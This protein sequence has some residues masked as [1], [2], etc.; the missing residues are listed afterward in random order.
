MHEARAEHVGSHQVGVGVLADAIV[1]HWLV[2]A[3]QTV[4]HVS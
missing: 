3:L 4:R 2:K 1:N